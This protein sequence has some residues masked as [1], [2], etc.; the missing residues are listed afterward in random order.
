MVWCSLLVAA[1]GEPVA[2]PTPVLEQVVLVG[3]VV[4]PADYYRAALAEAGF[5]RRPFPA[6]AAAQRL[7]KLLRRNGYA[8][9]EV[10]AAVRNGRPALIIDEGRLAKV[11]FVG[12]GSLRTLQLQLTVTLPHDVF[13]KELVASQLDALQHDLGLRCQY[14]VV[15]VVRD[16]NGVQ[17]DMFDEKLP[18]R[19]EL[20]IRVAQ[21]EW[22]T[23]VG[24]HGTINGADGLRLGVSYGDRGLFWAQDAWRVRGDLGAKLFDETSQTPM[25]LGLA[26]AALDLRWYTPPFAGRRLR[27]FLWLYGDY[28]V[29]Q[30]PLEYVDFYHW[31]R[32]G[33]VANLGWDFGGGRLVS[34]GLGGEHR[35]LTSVTQ[36][37]DPPRRFAPFGEWRLVSVAQGELVFDP[38]EP[39]RDR[40]HW[41]KA[42]ARYFRNADGDN[43]ASLEG[44]YQKVWELGWHDLWLRGQ[45][46]ALL[47]TYPLM[48][49]EPLSRFVRGVFPDEFT[50]GVANLSVEFRFSLVRDLL[51]L[52]SYLDVAVHAPTRF[53]PRPAPVQG[54]FA[55][56]LGA[57]LLILD[58]IQADL[59]YGL[60]LM[61]DGR[62]DPG[63]ALRMIKAY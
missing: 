30:R 36:P 40:H 15:R 57:N 42:E 58:T 56:G 45:G 6:R 14:S 31:L 3:N 34:L 23:G 55:A 63:L 21:S 24:L 13:H 53:G 49:E 12:A 59:Y 25:S 20:H 32:T 60:G 29:R 41:L 11:V 16:H 38:K 50:A 10:R 1:A 9:A 8:L 28:L 47:G 43:E 19:F 54:A 33:T 62:V 35:A 27:T 44:A 61:T 17:L 4:F 22:N 39:R 7:Q 2:P 48:D 51:K 18:P 46:M 26:R 37:A 5:E 52:S